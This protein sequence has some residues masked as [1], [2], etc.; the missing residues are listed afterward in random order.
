MAKNVESLIQ[1]TR[2]NKP[3]SIQHGDLYVVRLYTED[4][5]DAHVYDR[6]KHLW[7]KN[8]GQT[9]CILHYFPDG[10]YRYVYWPMKRIMWAQMELEGQDGK[11]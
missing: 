9:L 8:K 6:A 3:S 10:S 4:S 11:E 7:W 5:A 2:G 1:P